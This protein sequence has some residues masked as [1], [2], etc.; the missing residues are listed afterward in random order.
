MDIILESRGASASWYE[1][2]EKSRVRYLA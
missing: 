1:D 2:D